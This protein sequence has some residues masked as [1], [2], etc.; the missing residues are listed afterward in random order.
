MWTCLSLGKILLHGSHR[1]PSFRH[2]AIEFR[3]YIRN[4]TTPVET[5]AT[6]H[7]RSTL[8]QALRSTTNPTLRYTIQ[9]IMPVTAKYPAVWIA[10]AKIAAAALVV[11]AKCGK[12]RPAAAPDACSA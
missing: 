10:V 4:V 8:N 2:G 6:A 7:S 9:A 12:S 11:A 3:F 1:H 5:S